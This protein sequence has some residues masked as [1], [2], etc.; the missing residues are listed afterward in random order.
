MTAKMTG[1][2]A[3]DLQNFEETPCILALRDGEIRGIERDSVRIFKGVPFAAAPVGDLRFRPPQRPTP[4]SGVRE[5]DEYG[6]APMQGGLSGTASLAYLGAPRN[7]D[8]LY[9][10]VWAP[11]AP[12]PHPVLVWIFGGSNQTGSA[13]FPLFDGAVFARRGIVCVTISYRVGVYGFLELGEVL[14]P[15]YRGSSENGLRDIV[16]ALEWVQENIAAF[17]GDPARV[18]AGGESAGG[19]NIC[20]LMAAPAA[21]DLFQSA[22]VQSGGEVVASLEEANAVARIFNEG[23]LEAGGVASDLLAMPAEEITTLQSR[24]L[25]GRPRS[26][27]GVFGGDLI[28]VRPLDAIAQGASSQV[29]LLIGTNRDESIMFIPSTGTAGQ[30]ISNADLAAND[31]V[32][33]RYAP[34]FAGLSPLEQRVRF[35]TA[36]DFWRSSSQIALARARQGAAETYVYR[37]DQTAATGAWAGRAV[38]A[39]ELPYVWNALDAP[40]AV[41]FLTGQADAGRRRLGAEICDRW[42]NFIHGHPPDADGALPWPCFDRDHAVLLFDEKVRLE[43]LDE[44]ELELWT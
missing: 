32:F 36:R 8:C 11:A 5:A 6:P 19:M 2:S 42:A 10:N 18:T 3:D 27:R 41:A 43:P 9:L 30:Q 4:W 7:E 1:I 35:M 17:G 28:P 23:L 15:D 26:F 13:S 40:S 14:G 12:G 37:F 38:H 24:L 29:R 31:P 33:N 39:A 21:R 22:I 20:S 16:A 44:A 34:R 25:D